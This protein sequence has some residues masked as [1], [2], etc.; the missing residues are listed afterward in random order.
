MAILRTNL[1]QI[2]IYRTSS[3]PQKLI[4]G[5]NLY[6]DQNFKKFEFFWYM[7]IYIIEMALSNFNLNCFTQI[8]FLMTRIL[9][10][11]IQAVVPGFTPSLT[12]ESR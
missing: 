8:D 10:P 9:V 6:V 7:I 3:I 12:G 2:V 4:P 11:G 5:L 1:C